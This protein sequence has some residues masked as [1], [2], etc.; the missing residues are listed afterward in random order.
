MID[1]LNQIIEYGIERNL[2]QNFTSTAH[3]VPNSSVVIEG[4]EMLNFGSCSYLGLEKHNVLKE[5]T[6]DAVTKYG[7]QFSSSRTYLSHG[8]YYELE[9][10]LRDIFQRP[11][12]VTASTTLG[13]LA[14]IPIVVG[15][16]DAVVLDLQVHSSIQMTIQQLKAKGIPTYIIRHNCMESLEMK[17]KHLYNKYDKIWYFA[18]GVYS[19]YGDYAPFEQLDALMA[20]YEKFHLY[21]DDAHG[22]G[23]TG[24]N[25]CGVVHS[26]MNNTEK[27]ILAV[28]LNKSFGAAGGCLIFPN[29]EMERK[30][31]NCGST[32]I[33]SGP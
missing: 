31:R 32:Y 16:N 8:L 30:V 14:T 22:M 27:M 9:D 6:I 29:A 7:T 4:H 3:N 2:L 24:E 15:K 20:K 17:I 33:F 13:H 1:T 26:R 11:L 12:I 25:G 23:W 10:T 21:I 18:D 19:M 5:G 28:S